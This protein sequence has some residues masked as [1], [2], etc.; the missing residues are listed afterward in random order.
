MVRF[1]EMGIAYFAA[2][3]S[4]RRTSAGFAERDMCSAN[5]NEACRG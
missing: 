1:I 5:A 4:Y 3:Q 2:G